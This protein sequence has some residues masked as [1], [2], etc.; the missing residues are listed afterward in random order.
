[1][2]EAQWFLAGVLALTLSVTL[3]PACAQNTTVTVT[4]TSSEIQPTETN[5]IVFDPVNQEVRIAAEI[6]GVA[7]T[8]PTW[9]AIV[10]TGGSMAGVALFKT[11]A[12]P[13]MVYPMLTYFGGVPGNNVPLTNYDST[14][15]QGSNISITVT[16]AGA[17]QTYNLI[18]VVKDPSATSSSSGKGIQMVFSGNLALN[19]A[20]GTGCISCFYSCPLAIVSNAAQ[21]GDD[22]NAESKAGQA[23]FLGNSAI[24]PPSGTIVVLTYKVTP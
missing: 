10:Y 18:D 4:G 8:Q 19:E 16:W 22:Y 7:F 9:N 1:L 20:N 17:P 12:T 24:L 21:D 23:G 14:Y 5:P 15:A 3:L 13:D 6:N 11:F 2:C